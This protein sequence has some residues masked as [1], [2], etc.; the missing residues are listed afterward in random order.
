MMKILVV[1]SSLMLTL[2]SLALDPLTDGELNKVLGQGGVYL[3]GELKINEAGGPLNNI[4]NTTWG[5][6]S[7][8]SKN[9]RCGAR[10]ALKNNNGWTVIDNLRGTF[11]FEGMTLKTRQIKKDSPHDYEGNVLEI[12]LP[13]EVK[14]TNVSYTLATSNEARPTDVNFRQSDILGV[15][16]NGDINFQGNLLLFPT[17]Q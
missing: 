2:P 5:E 3:S 7:S 1:I 15:N 17:G 14:F 13:S 6:C 10:I 12:G 11:S 4:K 16:I 8:I 9:T